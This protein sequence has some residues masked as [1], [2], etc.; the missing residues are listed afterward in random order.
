MFTLHTE[1]GN[2]MIILFFCILVILSICLVIKIVLMSK[3]FLDMYAIY[4]ITSSGYT[5]DY[6]LIQKYGFFVPIVNKVEK[7]LSASLINSSDIFLNFKI[8]T[9]LDYLYTLEKEIRRLNITKKEKN[10]F[11]MAS[12]VIYSLTKNDRFISCLYLSNNNDIELTNKRLCIDVALIYLN[13]IS[14]IDIEEFNDL[15]KV[16]LDIINLFGE[17]S[18][19]VPEKDLVR[20]FSKKLEEYFENEKVDE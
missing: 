5:N 2:K 18:L 9:S 8:N 3:I 15:S 11:L 16:E 19:F 6:F 4:L 10:K 14:Y 13:K 20:I 12:L 1:G 17:V 7:I